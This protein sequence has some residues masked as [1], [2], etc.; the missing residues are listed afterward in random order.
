MSVAIVD[1]RPQPDLVD[2]EAGR[3]QLEEVDVAIDRCFSTDWDSADGIGTMDNFYMQTFPTLLD[4]LLSGKNGTV[5]AGGSEAEAMGCLW[6][7]EH[8]SHRTSSSAGGLVSFAVARLLGAIESFQRHPS[9][10]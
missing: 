3:V 9:L 5:L 8:G 6:G 4:Q 2:I 1:P 7:S 10:Q